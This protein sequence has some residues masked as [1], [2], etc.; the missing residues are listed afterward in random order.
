MGS[1]G[2]MATNRRCISSLSSIAAIQRRGARR[3]VARQRVERGFDDLLDLP[4]KAARRV[5]DI[6]DH[7]QRGEVALEIG[8]LVELDRQA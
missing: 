8:G 4:R 7:Q 2:R 5:S 3:E 6:L 1:G